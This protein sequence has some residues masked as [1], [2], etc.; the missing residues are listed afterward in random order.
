MNVLYRRRERRRTNNVHIIT[1]I[2][3]QSR[4]D[5]SYVRLEICNVKIYSWFEHHNYLDIFPSP[6]FEK[7]S[8]QGY[9]YI[10]VCFIRIYIYIYI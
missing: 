1:I 2:I 7:E 4:T 3:P 6:L 5:I 10:Y 9:I 8:T